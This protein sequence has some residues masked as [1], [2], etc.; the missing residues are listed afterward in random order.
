MKPEVI[1][2]LVV[3][4]SYSATARAAGSAR[5]A[6]ADGYLAVDN[7]LSAL[8]LDRGQKLPR[9]HGMKIDQAFGCCGQVFQDAGATRE[10]ID[11]FFQAWQD[12]RY[13]A[14]A[15]EPRQAVLYVRLTE[16]VVRAVVADLARRSGQA[17]DELESEVYERAFGGARSLIEGEVNVIHDML[18]QELEDHGDRYGAKLGKKL[19]NPS[20]FADVLILASDSVSQSIVTGD[21]EVARKVAELY[22]AFVDLVTHIQGARFIGGVEMAEAMN[23]LL[24]VRFSYSGQSFEEMAEDW[25]ALMRRIKE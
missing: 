12:V 19:A 1:D 23:F 17:I 18:Q 24:S 14:T 13:T 8:L 2:R 6:V 5:H 3:A 16:R 11:S 9:V 10:E 25:K 4:F 20:N 15:Q 22:R 7:A 21:E